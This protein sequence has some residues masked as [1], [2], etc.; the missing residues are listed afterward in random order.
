M[1]RPCSDSFGYSLRR[2]VLLLFVLYSSCWFYAAFRVTLCIVAH[3]L[4]VRSIAVITQYGIPNCEHILYYTSL[5]ATA[6]VRVRT[7]HEVL[8]CNVALLSFFIALYC[9]RVSQYI[10]PGVYSKHYTIA[11]LVCKIVSCVDCNLG[12][13]VAT[14]ERCHSC[15]SKP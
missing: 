10:K 13:I 6:V 12:C 14:H 3:F 9:I 7:S 4:Y 11:N 8:C 5:C 2:L 15:I 1:Y